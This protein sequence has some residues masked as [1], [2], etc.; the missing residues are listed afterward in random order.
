[1]LLLLPCLLL[2]LHVLGVGV[3]VLLLLL[4]AQQLAAPDAQLAVLQGAGWDAASWVTADAAP[5]L[6][7]GARQ[8][9]L[10]TRY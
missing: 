8:L 9:R 3:L 5:R 6:V 7:P 4:L 10:S 1:M 2:Q